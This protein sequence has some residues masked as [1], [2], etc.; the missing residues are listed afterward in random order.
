MF[1]AKTEFDINQ[2]IRSTAVSFE[3]T[4]RKKKIAIELILTD[5]VFVYAD[6]EKI[7]QVLYNLL[8]NAIK[9][10]PRDSIIKIETTEK[11][12]KIFISVK[13]SGI[14]IPKEELKFVFDRF[15]KSDSSRGRDRRGTGLGLAI[16]KEIIK[17][18]DENINVISTEGVGT[19][20]TFSLPIIEISEEGDY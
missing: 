14:G 2:V 6:R 9:F 19:E 10:S 3:G 18:H 15:F 12:S 8:D 17:S 11:H 1:L 7:E 5:S 16:V 20:F 4:C 13:D